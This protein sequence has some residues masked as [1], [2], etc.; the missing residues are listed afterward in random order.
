[1]KRRTL[2]DLFAGAG[3]LSCGLEMA[4]FHP[5]LANELEPA[6]AKTY[7]HNHPKTDLLVGDVRQICA[8]DLKKRLG[9]KQG[10]VDL[11]AG[12][13]PCQGF[14]INA[15]IGSLYKAMQVYKHASVTLCNQLKLRLC[16]QKTIY[17][18]C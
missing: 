6:Y 12:G 13:P 18:T 7:Q 16:H 1:M 2:I 5:V 8:S 11:L 14:S 3:G 15:P 9:L 10:E 4:G 17:V